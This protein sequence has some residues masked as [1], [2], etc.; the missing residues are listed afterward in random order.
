M[1]LLGKIKS[2][3]AS[4]GDLKQIYI[5]F[6]RSLLEHSCTGCNS[7][8]T[9]ENIAEL[10]RVQKCALK[11]IFEGKYKNYQKALDKIDL[12]TLAERRNAL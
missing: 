11:I 8:W 4:L 3:N 1:Q 7:M 5:T 6:I 12:E 9:E 2:F 10:E